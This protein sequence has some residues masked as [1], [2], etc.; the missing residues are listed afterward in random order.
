MAY[1]ANVTTYGTVIFTTVKSSAAQ[2]PTYVVAKVSKNIFILQFDA[3]SV[4]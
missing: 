4:S 1:R 2:G 3:L